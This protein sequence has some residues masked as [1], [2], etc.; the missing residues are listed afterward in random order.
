MSKEKWSALTDEQKTAYMRKVFK[1]MNIGDCFD[2]AQC[3]EVHKRLTE[4]GQ[5]WGVYENPCVVLQLYDPIMASSIMSWM[6]GCYDDEGNRVE[7]TKG[8]S[9]PIFGYKMIELVF[10]KG[11][12]MEFSDTEKQVLREAMRI[13]N[14]KTKMPED[15]KD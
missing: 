9:A 12:L 6:Y 2:Y 8:D 1:S 3:R 15:K 10:D 7:Y 5:T 13:I 14:E 11:S 4:N